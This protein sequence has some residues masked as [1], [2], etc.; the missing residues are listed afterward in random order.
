MLLYS[1][2]ENKDDLDKLKNKLASGNFSGVKQKVHLYR[3]FWN[4]VTGKYETQTTPVILQEELSSQ[5]AA[6]KIK[7]K[8]DTDEVNKWD[9]SHLALT[10]ENADNRFKEGKPGGLFPEG[11]IFFGSKMEYY[12][13]LEDCGQWQ[14]CFTGYCTQPPVY[15]P[16]SCLVDIRAMSQM[17]W[18][19]YTDAETISHKVTGEIL[20]SADP[21][22]NQKIF[23]TLETGVGRILSL[24]YARFDANDKEISSTH[25]TEKRDYTLRGLSEAAQACE[26]TLKQALPQGAKLIADYIYWHKNISINK[27]VEEII[28][29]AGIEDADI[30]P[31]VFE[32]G[33]P[34]DD[35]AD[36]NNTDI[37]PVGVPSYAVLGQPEVLY[38]LKITEDGSLEP[39]TFE[40]YGD[41]GKPTIITW[42]KIYF[43]KY[44]SIR[45]NSVYK[46]F[47]VWNFNFK[48]V[49]EVAEYYFLDADK[50]PVLTFKENANGISYLKVDGSEI[51]LSVSG[52]VNNPKN[53]FGGFKITEAGALVVFDAEGELIYSKDDF[54]RRDIV[55]ERIYASRDNATITNIKYSLDTS[56]N[57]IKDDSDVSFINPKYLSRVLDGGDKITGWGAIT[58]N[59]YYTDDFS[60]C[61]LKYRVSDDGEKFGDW[62]PIKFGENIAEKNRYLQFYLE[63]ITL[64]GNE[65]PVRGL[66]VS[67]Y[68]N[69]IK[70]EL[71]DY[72]GYSAFD[73]LKDLAKLST[74]EMGFNTKG[75]FFFRPRYSNNE[76]K[77]VK[78]ISDDK[79]I[80]VTDAQQ[81]LSRLATKV[82]VTFGEH[83]VICDDLEDSEEKRYSLKY[84]V[85]V[86]EVS[87][88]RLLPPENVN[89]AHAVAPTYYK[90]F[91]KLQRYLT[92]EI[93]MDLGIELGD[94]V[95]LNHNNSLT[96]KI[97]YTDYT[98]YN[99][100]STY[101][102]LCRVVG[103][104]TDFK[105]KTTVLDLV[106]ITT[107]NDA[108][109]PELNCFPY[110]T[111]GVWD[112]KI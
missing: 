45:K 36:I 67:Y 14:L 2:S 89:L 34:V 28:E 17:D 110:E 31:V 86:K 104:E 57:I 87:S 49:N 75:A 74:Y 50:N 107:P 76:G 109:K 3:R 26:I 71:A 47:G 41:V 6:C 9:I 24:K 40:R 15:R 38:N 58:A 102:I 55:C 95:K 65:F 100:L 13:G 80:S 56:K 10:L 32:T 62:I 83:Q 52:S 66:K 48:K 94:I 44:S 63:I 53:H 81:D 108:P 35:E 92:A 39:L 111:T 7:W 51:S 46:N 72:S 64:Y 1:S 19:K 21:E 69:D 42:N 101:G 88:P 16:D 59:P 85:R 8:L 84:G 96:T 61:R 99:Q 93:V 70:I 43:P 30:K 12:I 27:A 33:I 37:K 22:N 29:E 91:S 82:V 73:A 54:P 20:Q 18:L 5:K 97:E 23:T 4:N 98:K 60:E 78:E 79:I 105:N 90:E 25:L 11:F 106:D 112:A 68:I 103:I 77:G